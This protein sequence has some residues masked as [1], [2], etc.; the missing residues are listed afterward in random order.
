MVSSQ[1]ADAHTFQTYHNLHV[2]SDVYPQLL[3]SQ[4]S[5]TKLATQLQGRV[6]TIKTYDI[7][8]EALQ[9]TRSR[10]NP[11]LNSLTKVL[12]QIRDIAKS[13]QN[14]GKSLALCW[15]GFE[16]L[17]VFAMQRGHLPEEMDLTMF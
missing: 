17:Q 12:T 6:D 7:K 14:Q 8:G 11:E 4:I 16:D 10:M 13:P 5:T 2:R 3:L 15:S 9:E 1:Y